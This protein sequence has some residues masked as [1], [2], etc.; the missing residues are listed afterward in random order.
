MNLHEIYLAAQLAKNDNV[1]LSDYY[2]KSQTDDLISEKV[3][4][5]D[6]MGLSQNSFT[7]AEKSKLSGLEN[8]DDT[9]IKE[10]IDA[11]TDQIF[12]RGINISANSDLN[13]YT[14]TGIYY[15][16]GSSVSATLANTPYKTGEFK[17]EVCNISSKLNVTQK[18][19]PNS[20]A[21][22]CF[23]MRALPGGSDNS[24]GPWFKYQGEA[25]TT[26]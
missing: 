17:L 11:I 24:F 23:F 1:N 20:S 14:N 10:Q 5:A 12:G 13:N 21:L 7:N 6:G 25:V 2:T 9:E 18:L 16:T 22:G 26:S 8:Y 4:K 15:S 3:D 19:Y